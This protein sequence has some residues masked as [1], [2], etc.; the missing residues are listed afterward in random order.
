MC[1]RDSVK[2]VKTSDCSVKDL[3]KTLLPKGILHCVHIKDETCSL[4]RRTLTRI[5]LKTP[6]PT[7]VADVPDV[8][9][10]SNDYT[11]RSGKH[12][13][14]F[15]F[16]NQL[17]GLATRSTETGTISP[18]LTE[19]ALPGQDTCHHE[20]ISRRAQRT[21]QDYLVWD[22]LDCLHLFWHLGWKKSEVGSRTQGG[23]NNGTPKDAT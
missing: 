6:M 10:M 18:R 11:C 9:G 19:D 22:H 12:P 8:T 13:S 3:P 1:I 23:N 17:V 2:L 5:A 14:H 4:Q 16:S 20:S 21:Y 15:L 7:G